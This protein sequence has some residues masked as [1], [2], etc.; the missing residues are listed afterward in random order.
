MYC[1]QRGKNVTTIVECFGRFDEEDT[2][3]FMQTL[4][5]LQGQGLKN[6]V[7]N[8]STIFLPR[9][10]SSQAPAICS[11]ILAGPWGNRLPGESKKFC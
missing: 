8:L 2:N 6:I 7:L 3:H 10:K 9:S 5:Q 1:E 4:E 11:G